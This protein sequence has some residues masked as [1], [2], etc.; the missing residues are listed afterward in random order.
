MIPNQDCKIFGKISPVLEGSSCKYKIVLHHNCGI[1]ILST[2]CRQK[3]GWG[4]N[5][6][7]FSY[8]SSLIHFILFTLPLD[9]VFLDILIFPH[10]YTL[11]KR[12]EG[13]SQARWNRPREGDGNG[14]CEKWMEY[15]QLSLYAQSYINTTWEL[16]FFFFFKCILSRKLSTRYGHLGVM[17]RFFIPW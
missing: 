2:R 11:H 14:L 3:R 13:S 7:L 5:M 1:A 8:F 12:Q 6:G 9:F 10:T 16:I 17:T 15:K 4:D